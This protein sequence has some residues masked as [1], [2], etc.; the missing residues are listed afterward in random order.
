[1]MSSPLVRW[2][3]G[4]DAPD[5]QLGGASVVFE[6]PIP[7]WGWFL[8]IVGCFALAWWTYRR[9]RGASGGRVALGGIR[10]ALLML[11]AV[12]IAGPALRVAHETVEED[13]V[14]V[15]ADRSRSMAIRD[16]DPDA[17]G[18][19]ATR[20]QSLQSAL[21]SSKSTMPRIATPTAPMP[22]HTA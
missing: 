12:L 8:V 20:D 19:R 10:A 14:V 3:L 18:A 15:L 16:G 5:E 2:L 17:Q 21:G 11:L 1:M 4:I 7:G 22:V 9:L 13:W 6:R